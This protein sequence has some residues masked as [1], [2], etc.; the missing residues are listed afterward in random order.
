MSRYA[1]SHLTAA[2]SNLTMISLCGTASARP[3]VCHFVIGSPATPANLAG[4][5]TLKRITA[6]PTGGTALTEENIDAGTQA[7][8][9][10]AVGGT[11]TE[12][13]YAAGTGQEYVGIGLNQ[14]ATFQWWAN[15]GYEPRVALGTANGIGIRSLAHGGTPNIKTSL[16]WEE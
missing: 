12:P 2:G 15:P 1:V 11:M 8:L 14:Q 6:A 9:C 7:G 16:M 5:F 10:T 4:E 3:M 13:T